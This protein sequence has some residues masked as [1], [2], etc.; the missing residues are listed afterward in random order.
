MQKTQEKYANQSWS[1]VSKYKMK[2]EIWLN[3]ENVK[4]EKSAK[5]LDDK[6]LYTEKSNKW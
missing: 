3:T 5:K 1:A 6:L 2:D 4:T